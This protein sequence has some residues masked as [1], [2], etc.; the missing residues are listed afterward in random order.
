MTDV[1]NLFGEQ[2]YGA[3]VKGED[4]VVR[5]V[6]THVIAE[7]EH[8]LQQAREGEIIGISLVCMGP[9]YDVSYHLV[10]RVGGYAMLG[11]QQTIMAELVEINRNA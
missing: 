11:A 10:G 5:T 6:N 3:T 7:L 4:G 9:Q 8:K 1:V 2:S